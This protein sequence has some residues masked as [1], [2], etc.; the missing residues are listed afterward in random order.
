MIDLAESF[1]PLVDLV[2][3]L[4]ASGRQT[5]QTMYGMSGSVA[6]HNTDMWGDSAPQ[7]NDPPSTFWPMGLVW[8]ATQTWEYY[9]FTGDLAWLRNHYSVFRDCAVFCLNFL[10]DY[11]EYKV[12]NP[13]ISPENSYFVPGT[14]DKA[15][16]TV[17]STIDN[18]L[19]WT[20]FGI[21]LKCHDLLALDD[22]LYVEAYRTA[23]PPVKVNSWGGIQEW[24]ED[25]EETE[26]A[27]RHLSPLY[28]IYP[29][30]QITP[31][32]LA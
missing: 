31:K 25:Y 18:S 13:S 23:L 8:L 15:S 3:R 32:I 21:I 29:G 10:T 7:D 6:H 4:N 19:L 17:G 30:A 27:H 22:D 24:I 9:L 26:P 2:T 20:L 11:G 12:T 1:E 16:F 14:R 28:G 5:A